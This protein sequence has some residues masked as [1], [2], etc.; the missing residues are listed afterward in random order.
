MRASLKSTCHPPL[1]ERQWTY[2][3]FKSANWLYSDLL[4]FSHAKGYIH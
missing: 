1:C 3:P 2:G 4:Q